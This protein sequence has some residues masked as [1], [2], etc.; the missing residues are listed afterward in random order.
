MACG[1]SPET[2][3]IETAEN[4]EFL[5]LGF[6]SP[7]IKCQNNLFQVLQVTNNIYGFTFELL[8]RNLLTF[9]DHG[10]YIY[11]N[12]FANFEMDLESKIESA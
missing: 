4:Q 8:K 1:F 5:I 10:L 11:I 7:T 9:G 12:Q 3:S 2:D 6:V